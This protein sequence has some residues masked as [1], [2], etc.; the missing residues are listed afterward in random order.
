M[1]CSAED[2]SPTLLCVGLWDTTQLVALLEENTIF[3][4]D[5]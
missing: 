2:V 5:R 1:M 3:T 4:S